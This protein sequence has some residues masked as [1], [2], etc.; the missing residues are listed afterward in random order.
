VKKE[1]VQPSFLLYPIKLKKLQ[2][3]II[4]AQTTIALE[5]DS[6]KAIEEGS[7][8]YIPKPLNKATY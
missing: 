1:K 2:K 6:E 5:G 4:L 8:D 7:F 3:G